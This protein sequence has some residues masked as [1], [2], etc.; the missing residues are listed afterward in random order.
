MKNIKIFQKP[1]NLLIFDIKTGQ[2]R[3]VLAVGTI[4]KG[5]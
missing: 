4:K 3:T 1:K 5:K 2:T